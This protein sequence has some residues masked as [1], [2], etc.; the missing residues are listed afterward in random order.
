MMNE[1]IQEIKEQCTEKLTTYSYSRGNITETYF[2]KDKFAEL[3][4][5]ECLDLVGNKH[6][7]NYA[8]TSISN[9]FGVE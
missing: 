2:D 7:P 9:H 1:R 8:Y 5:R 3:I 6:C 4:V